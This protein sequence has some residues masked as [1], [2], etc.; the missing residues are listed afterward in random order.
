LQFQET[1]DAYL[2]TTLCTLGSGATGT[3][4]PFIAAIGKTGVFIKTQAGTTV[5]NYRAIGS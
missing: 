1:F 4:I 5:T 2:F 3:A